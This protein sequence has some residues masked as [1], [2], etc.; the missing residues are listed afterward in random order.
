MIEPSAIAHKLQH[1]AFQCLQNER[2][3]PLTIATRSATDATLDVGLGWAGEALL[4]NLEAESEAL[5]GA[6][7]PQQIKTKFHTQPIPPARQ[8]KLNQAYGNNHI[9]SLIAVASAK[10]GVGKSTLA[11]HMA[12]A[13]AEAGARVGLLDADIQGPNLPLLFGLPAATQPE[14]LG[15]GDERM[16]AAVPVRGVRLISMAMLAAQQ[17]AMVWRGP[18]ISGALKQLLLRTFWSELD[19]LIVDMPPGTG[20]ISLTLAQSAP[21]SAAVLVSTADPMALADTRRGVSMYQKLKIPLLGWIENMSFW[22]CPKCDDQHAI[23]S[24]QH[25]PEPLELNRLAQIP[26]LPQVTAQAMGE[27]LDSGLAGNYWRK[28]AFA[29]ASALAYSNQS[30]STETIKIPES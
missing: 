15:K 14:I 19:Y 16:M 12:L 4:A 7:Y 27:G 21:V 6:E 10:G 17:Q 5:L 22:H 9:T 26:L 18:M 25:E 3:G 1:H 8:L 20:D 24:S 11:A 13:L 2:P 29:V 30:Q 28:A 23:F